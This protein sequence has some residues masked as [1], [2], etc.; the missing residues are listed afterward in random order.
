VYSSIAVIGVGTLGGFLAESLSELETL[1]QL[2]IV[3]Y[4]KVESKNCKN[5]IYSR[6]YVG[7][8]KVDVLYKIIKAQK[9]MDS[10]KITKISKKFIEGKTKIP[11]CDLVIDCRDFVYNRGKEI[12]LRMYISDRCLILDCRKNI[13][14][15]TSYE[16]K[17]ISDLLKM[18]LRFA[19]SSVSKFINEGDLENLIKEQSVQ[20]IYL[21]HFSKLLN[22]ETPKE[23]EYVRD[24]FV[25]ENKLLCID[26][27]L[28]SILENN[29]KYDTQ[30]CIGDRLSPLVSKII[31]KN[32]FENFNDI[33]TCLAT[34]INFPQLIY[35]EYIISTVVINNNLYI[36]LLPGTGAA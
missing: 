25:G 3:D 34:M 5:S 32:K 1:K 33:T 4:D 8:L 30:V 22:K 23:E 28:E 24:S 12:D 21:D 9:D 35:G 27:N 16:G 19:T 7:E 29:K 2:V 11:S 20:K 14:Y 17:Y 18:D 31:P 36:Q 10:L 15:E 26:E 6:K 13:K